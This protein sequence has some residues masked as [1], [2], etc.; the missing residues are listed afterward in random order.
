MMS[1]EEEYETVGVI[2]PIG[3]KNRMDL[4]IVG[5]FFLLSR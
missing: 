5:F 3:L 1:N 4:P 2:I